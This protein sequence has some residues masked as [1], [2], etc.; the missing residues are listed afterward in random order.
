MPDVCTLKNEVVTG[1]GSGIL[2]YK[3]SYRKQQMKKNRNVLM[4][5][6]RRHKMETK[7]VKKSLLM[8]RIYFL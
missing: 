6:R 3:K 8:S 5:I 7:V 4:K 2:P 1:D